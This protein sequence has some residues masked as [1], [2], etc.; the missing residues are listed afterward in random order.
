MRLSKE[1]KDEIIILYNT[2]KTFKQIAAEIG[3]SCQTV[4]RT[5]KGVTT[6]DSKIYNIPEK[7][8][9]ELKCMNERYGK[10]GTHRSRK[11]K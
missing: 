11:V 9:Q 2:G 8:K 7:I 6:E 3:C 1:K 4:S 5:I 10:N